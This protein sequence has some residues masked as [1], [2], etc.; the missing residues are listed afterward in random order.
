M[1]KPVEYPDVE[2][3]EPKTSSDSEDAQLIQGN[4]KQ[5]RRR[6][7][8]FVLWQTVGVFLFLALYTPLVFMMGRRKTTDD[9]T[10]GGKI[11]K[12]GL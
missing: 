1:E 11:I 12:C 5:T 3:S 2:Y 7:G 8:M 10:H 4:T 6:R 9:P